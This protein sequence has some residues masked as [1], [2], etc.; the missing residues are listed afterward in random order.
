MTNTLTRCRSLISAAVFGA[1]LCGMTALPS[2]VL[3]AT[4]ESKP[5]VK[6]RVV[7]ISSERLITDPKKNPHP[8]Y[9]LI[10]MESVGTSNPG[11]DQLMLNSMLDQS[12]Q[13]LTGK[14]TPKTAWK[15]LFKPTDVVG[16]KV[17]CIAGRGLSTHPELVAAIVAGLKLAD[18]PS[19]KIIV[20]DRTKRELIGAGF[21][22]NETEGS[23][24][25]RGSEGFYDDKLTKQGSFKGHLTRIITDKVTAIINVPIL[26]DHGSAG[27]TAAMK[28]HYGSIDN[29]G[30][31]H[32]DN[33]AAIADLNAVPAIKDKTRL[34]VLDAIN[35]TCNGGPGQDPR[36]IWEPKTIVVSTDPVALDYQA[37]QM[38]EK[39]REQ[40]KLPTLT[41]EG[42]EPKWIAGAAKNGLGTNDPKDMEVIRKVVLP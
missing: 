41:A 30:D 22:P 29:P 36:Y 19:D 21:Q 28:N 3:A 15:A 38:I 39:R 10:D 35:A 40:I 12:V 23:V 26:K 24:V 4:T 17:N 11:I 2:N 14:P 42:R 31:Q 1:F 34:I 18:V 33:C 7:F 8:L 16:I 6:S 5:A 20:W 9:S 27:I 13:V 37:W 32:G 25:V